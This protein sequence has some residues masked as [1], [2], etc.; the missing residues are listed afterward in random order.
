[1]NIQRSVFYPYQHVTGP[2]SVLVSVRFGKTPPGGPAVVRLLSMDR[3]KAEI[4]FNLE[5]HVTEVLAGVA[6]ANTD[7]GGSLEVEAIEVVP[8]D[9]PQKAQA[10]YAAY[11]IAIA[12]QRGDV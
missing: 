10:E 4:Q 1:M 5:N 7:V 2:S 6:K 8:D 3:N 11:K 12:V 9:H